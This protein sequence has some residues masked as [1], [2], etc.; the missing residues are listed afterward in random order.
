MVVKRV[1]RFPFFDHRYRIA[2]SRLDIQ[3]RINIDCRKILDT[4]GFCQNGWDV[5]IEVPKKLLTSSGLQFDRGKNVDHST[6]SGF[7]I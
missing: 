4:A 2:V 6:L 3:F 7:D 1:K 5:V